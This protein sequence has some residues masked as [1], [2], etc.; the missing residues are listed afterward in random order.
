MV[1]A[2]A[3][4]EPAPSPA[5]D[6]PA[7]NKPP[8]NT[9]GADG[10]IRSYIVSEGETEATICEAFG[11]SKEQLYEYNRLPATARLKAGDEIMIPRVAKIR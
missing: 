2:P 5:D 10:V 7:A 9:V 4:P 6:P 8:A 11:I 3:A 1:D